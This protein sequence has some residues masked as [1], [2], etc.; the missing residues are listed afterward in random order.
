MIYGLTNVNMINPNYYKRFKVAVTL[1]CSCF[2]MNACENNVNDVKALSAKNGGVDVGKEVAIYMS[3]GGKMSA[4]IMAPIMNRY[5]EDSGKMVEFPKSIKVNFYKDSATIDS[6]LSADYAQ[7]KETENTV[8]LKDNVVVFNLQGD[9]LWCKEMYW[10]QATGKFHTDKDVIVK[11]HNPLAKTFGKGFEANQ[12]LTDIRIFKL[13]PNS[14][15]IINDS[16]ALHP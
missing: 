3:S 4:K 12:D 1:I 14:F 15:A 16:S 5:L 8:F 9:T 13:Q 6:K 7:Y 2:F 11:Q 10:D